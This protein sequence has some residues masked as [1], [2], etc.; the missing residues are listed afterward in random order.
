[1]NPGAVNIKVNIFIGVL[2]LQEEHLGDYQVGYMVI[3]GAAQENNPVFEQ[4]GID[5]VSPLTPA[6]LLYY[7]WYQ[8]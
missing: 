3:D 1:M 8:D 4:A 2:S 6:G 7:H 5:I